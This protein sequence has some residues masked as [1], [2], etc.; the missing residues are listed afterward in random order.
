VTEII[1]PSLILEIIIAHAIPVNERN[2]IKNTKVIK[3]EYLNLNFVVIFKLLA[4][5]R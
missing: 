3:I 1:S 2:P 5:T 4:T